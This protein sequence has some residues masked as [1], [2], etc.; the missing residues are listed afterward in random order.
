MI[1]VSV[2]VSAAR[3]A[4]GQLEF[5]CL[6]SNVQRSRKAKIIKR[7]IAVPGRATR[8][9]IA[10]RAAAA[11]RL[12]HLSLTA[13]GQRV[14][15]VAAWALIAGVRER[16]TTQGGIIICPDRASAGTVQGSAD[17]VTTSVGGVKLVAGVAGCRNRVVFRTTAPQPAGRTNL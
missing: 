13:L 17:I 8:V 12:E 5:E 4:T 1:M 9:G 10:R 2:G 3:R 15:F 14:I 6:T 16:H 11:I 7:I